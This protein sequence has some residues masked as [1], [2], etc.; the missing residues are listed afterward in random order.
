MQASQWELGLYA[1]IQLCKHSKKNQLSETKQ[2]LYIPDSESR[3]NLLYQT[4]LLKGEVAWVQL[5]G[6]H[7]DKVLGGYAQNE[8]GKTNGRSPWGRGLR[9]QINEV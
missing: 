7:A 1:F 8:V 6:Y 4:T 3:R 9:N 2:G 5:N